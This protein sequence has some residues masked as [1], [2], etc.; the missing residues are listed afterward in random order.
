[1]ILV[2]DNYDSFTYNLVALLHQT[3]EEVRTF[4]NDEITIEQ[5]QT[6]QPKGI[7]LSPGPGKPQDSGVCIS[8]VMQMHVPIMGVCL[9]HQLIAYLAGA[10]IMKTLQPIHGKTSMIFHDNS[11]I[12]EN[13]PNPVKV[14]RYH[15]LIVSENHL[16]SNI[17]ITARTK[18]GEIM[19]LMLKDQPYITGVQFHPES[20]LTEF[21]GKMIKNWVKL[22]RNFN[23]KAESNKLSVI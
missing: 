13:I 17:T 2:I 11:G 14:M 7:M 20:I 22:V 8:I 5:I 3:G 16:P 15:S 6:L 19:G 1:M 21:G 4:R 10:H 12:F 23:C 9:G 18:Q